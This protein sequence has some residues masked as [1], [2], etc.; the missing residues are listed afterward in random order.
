[1]GYNSKEKTSPLKDDKYYKECFNI[2]REFN[3]RM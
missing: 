3:F 1:M 2:K